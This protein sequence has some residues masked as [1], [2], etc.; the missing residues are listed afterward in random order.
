MF[1]NDYYAIIIHGDV[2]A[3]VL[4]YP[5]WTLFMVKDI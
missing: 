1:T 4:M 3:I 2:Q 5:I